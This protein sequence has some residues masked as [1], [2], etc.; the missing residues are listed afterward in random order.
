MPFGVHCAH[1]VILNELIYIGGGLT[2][3]YNEEMVIRYDPKS[4][5]CSTLAKSTSNCFA[6]ATVEGQLLLAGGWLAGGWERSTDVQLLDS[7]GDHWITHCYPKTMTGRASAAAV[8]YQNYLIV[9]CGHYYKD[10]VEILDCYT[11]KWHSASSLPVGGQWMT[12][13]AT[14]AHIYVSSQ[15]W[16]GGRSHVFSAHLPTL[17]YNATS[18]LHHTASAPIWQ[19]LP[20]PPVDAPTLLTLQNHLLLVGGESNR[21]E[22]HAYEPEKRRWTVCGQL[23]VGMCAPSCVVLPSG[24]LF[25]AGGNVEGDEIRSR[26]VWIGSFE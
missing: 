22:L 9:A 19:E 14:S 8:G 17:I 4:G 26:Q 24:N 5:D 1:A 15:F 16:R 13:V 6:L 2:S 20:P 25:V 12:A 10:T 11:R 21:K 7:D 23:P 3:E 18:A